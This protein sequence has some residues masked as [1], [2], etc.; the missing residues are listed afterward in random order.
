M[1]ELEETREMF[2][3]V[4]LIEVG[5]LVLIAMIFRSLTRSLRRTMSTTASPASAILKTQAK[6]SDHG[7]SSLYPPISPYEVNYLKVSPIHTL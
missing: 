2:Q 4:P 6:P 1:Q 7:T 5:T 3:H